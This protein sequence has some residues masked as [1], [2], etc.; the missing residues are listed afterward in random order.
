[1]NSDRTRNAIALVLASFIAP[2]LVSTFLLLLIP[3]AV[4]QRLYFKLSIPGLKPQCQSRSHKVLITGA[5]TPN[6]LF[7]ARALSQAGYTV[8]GADLNQYRTPPAAT[9]SRAFAKVYTVRPP[10]AS[11][12]SWLLLKD[13]AEI[14]QREQ[15]DAW[16]DH[17]EILSAEDRQY[18]QS[19]L[20]K[21]L[22]LGESESPAKLN[23]KHE[24]LCWLSTL[25]LTTPEFRQVKSRGELHDLL[26]DSR[27]RKSY[28][29]SSDTT[30]VSAN[31]TAVVLPRRTLS[32]TY[33]QVSKL[34][35]SPDQTWT[36]EEDHDSSQQ[37]TCY[38]L[39][40]SG[41]PRAFSAAT[42]SPSGSLKRIP[43]ES[44]LYRAMLRY[45][46][47]LVQHTEASFTHELSIDFRAYEATTS[48]GY[49][50]TILPVRCS[51]RRHPAIR[52]FSRIAAQDWAAASMERSRPLLN[53]ASNSLHASPSDVAEVI[54]PREI[55][56]IYCFPRDIVDLLLI[57]LVALLTLRLSISAF[58]ANLALL[59]ERCVSWDE[60]FFDWRDPLPSIWHY[61]VEAPLEIWFTLMS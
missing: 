4:N 24:F 2:L 43:E 20:P 17:F 31:T 60:K 34:R 26:N 1:M 28:R 47:A 30:I 33:G 55:P 27:G 53:G 3:Q 22:C 23:D 57:P 8:I 49:E 11:Y 19:T 7:T 9:W 45:I 6:G 25:G 10:S 13:L 61:S 46:Q 39:I 41:N 35:I 50:V 52:L 38:V 48:S 59:T 51:T 12:G 5:S 40:K 14:L 15:I 42:I 32:Q 16:I 29:L 37:L 44:G 36:L 18:T 58:A 56:G 54:V 21:L